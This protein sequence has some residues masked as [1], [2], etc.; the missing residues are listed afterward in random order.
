MVR[1]VM[2]SWIIWLLE[3]TNIS[4]FNLCK[5]YYIP[6]YPVTPITLNIAKVFGNRNMTEVSLYYIPF[7][8]VA[9]VHGCLLSYIIKFSISLHSN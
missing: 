8:G 2:L 6:K 3:V 5:N 1:E 7:T 4:F 9:S